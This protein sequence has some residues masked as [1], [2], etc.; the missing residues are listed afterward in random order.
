MSRL[1]VDLT[2]NTPRGVFIP[3]LHECARKVGTRLK[4][5]G[6]WS[7]ESNFRP[8]LIRHRKPDTVLGSLHRQI[9]RPL[10]SSHMDTRNTALINNRQTPDTKV[11]WH[12][13]FCGHQRHYCACQQYQSQSDALATHL[14]LQLQ[15]AELQFLHW[16][17]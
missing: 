6:T 14:P 8:E 13:W 9:Q 17:S 1:G 2:A 12:D 3:H 5:T 15:Y 11:V 16:R 4:G 7:H 10:F